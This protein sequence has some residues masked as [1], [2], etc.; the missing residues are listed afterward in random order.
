VATHSGHIS[1]NT[2]TC[3]GLHLVSA[4]RHRPLNVAVVVQELLLFSELSCDAPDQIRAR[5]LAKPWT[6]AVGHAEWAGGG[7]TTSHHC[8][9]VAAWSDTPVQPGACRQKQHFSMKHQSLLR[10][11]WH[12]SRLHKMISAWWRLCPRPRLS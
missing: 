3:G 10:A 9:P 5:M 11:S 4:Q 8:I 12:C 7:L 2:G 6:G 1:K